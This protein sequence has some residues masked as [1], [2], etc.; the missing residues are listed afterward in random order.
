[1]YLADEALNTVIYCTN[2]TTLSQVKH[3]SALLSRVL[4]FSELGYKTIITGQSI[5][6]KPS[7]MSVD[8]ADM[9]LLNVNSEPK[10]QLANIEYL[11][12]R[13]LK[14]QLVVARDFPSAKQALSLGRLCSCPVYYDSIETWTGYSVENGRK[15]FFSYY[16]T[17]L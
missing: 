14:V 2:Y 1:M 9:F 10:R 4:Y 11:L 13:P 7:I 6:G 15:R 17:W 3:N 8:Y 16:K 5:S 12:K